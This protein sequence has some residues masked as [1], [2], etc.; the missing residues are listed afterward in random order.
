MP[1]A[2]EMQA[3]FDTNKALVRRYIEACSAEFVYPVIQPEIANRP[4]I[5][6]GNKLY[7]Y[8]TL[9]AMGAIPV[10]DVVQVQYTIDRLEE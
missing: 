2:K 3:F 9:L 1:S 8:A 10:P 7:T 4:S 6:E 5:V